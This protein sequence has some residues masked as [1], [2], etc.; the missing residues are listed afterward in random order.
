[1]PVHAALLV[2]PNVKGLS[3]LANL[4]NQINDRYNKKKK[5]TLYLQ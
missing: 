5:N 2:Y 3:V 1:M 4:N